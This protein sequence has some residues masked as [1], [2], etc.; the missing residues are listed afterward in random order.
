[1][2]K[3]NKQGCARVG[4][5]E[6]YESHDGPVSWTVQELDEEGEGTGF[7][8]AECSSKKKAKHLCQWIHDDRDRVMGRGK[9][10]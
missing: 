8:I 6:P 3:K 1:M 2:N 4:V 9:Y 10:A 5:V 7:I